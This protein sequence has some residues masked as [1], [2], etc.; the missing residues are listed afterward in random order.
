VDG[1]WHRV[2]AALLAQVDADGVLDWTASFD[3]TVNRAHQHA[4]SFARVEGPVGRRPRG[5]AAGHTGGLVELHES[6]RPA[7]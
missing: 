3:S 5:D 1:T 6:A 7:R 2:H 4:T